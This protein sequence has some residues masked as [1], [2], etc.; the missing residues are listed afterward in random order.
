MAIT[1]RQIDQAFSDYGKTYGGVR[2]DYFGL[3]Y[4]K[5]EFGLSFENAATQIAF[6]CND[7]GFD[8]FT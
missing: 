2:E 7:Y 3:I 8:G 1:E 4:L 5:Q 6:G